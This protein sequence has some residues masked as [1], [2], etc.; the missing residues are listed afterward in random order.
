MAIAFDPQK[1]TFSPDYSGLFRL[2]NELGFIPDPRERFRRTFSFIRSNRGFLAQVGA[3]YYKNRNV[4]LLGG[5]IPLL[6][7]PNWLMDQ[8]QPIEVEQNYMEMGESIDIPMTFTPKKLPIKGT[9]LENIVEVIYE[10]N[11]DKSPYRNALCYRLTR[12]F[13]ENGVQRFEFSTCKYFDYINSCEYLMYDFARSL[14]QKTKKGNRAMG[15][16]NIEERH[17]Q[18][19]RPVDPFDLLNRSMVPGTNTLLVFLDID[20]PIMW[21]HSRENASAIAEAVNTVHV[22]PAGTFQPVHV[23]DSFHEQDFS[24]FA[25]VMR[26]FGEELYGDEEVIDPYRVKHNIFERDS[27]RPYFR[28][29]SRGLGKLFYAGMGLD[30]LTLKPEILTIMVFVRK[31]FEDIFG[32]V[33]FDAHNDEG[34]PFSVPFTKDM[35]HQ[36]FSDPKTLPAGA[37]CLYQAYQHFD[38]IQAA[39]PLQGKT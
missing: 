13:K 34:V 38:E 21:L 36:R 12:T 23:E 22:V 24:F 16:P 18:F 14:L 10:G 35:I 8:L 6:V 20:D 39:V 37:G 7:T 19:E 4:D 26:E 9:Y 17:L 15:T 30:C 5:V 25:N 2:A 31:D 27:I 1:G 32:P 11:I 33:A 28:L 29:C 3:T